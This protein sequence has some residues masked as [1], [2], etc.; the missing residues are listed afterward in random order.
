MDHSVCLGVYVHVQVILS[1]V[2][3][4][5]RSLCAHV[6]LCE[7]VSVRIC[8]YLPRA[9]GSPGKDKLFCD[10]RHPSQAKFSAAAQDNFPVG[11]G[12]IML[13]FEQIFQRDIKLKTI[14]IAQYPSG[15]I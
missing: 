7:S 8:K 14:T 13:R 3:A 11:E 5:L 1:L 10:H 15:S 6:T 12:S 9:E 2:V 4:Y